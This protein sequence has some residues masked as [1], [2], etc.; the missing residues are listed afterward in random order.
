[1][2]QI[3]GTFSQSNL[4]LSFMSYACTKTHASEVVSPLEIST[5]AP[6][7]NVPD[8]VDVLPPSLANQLSTSSDEKAVE[9]P[10]AGALD[11]VQ[12]LDPISFPNQPRKGSYSIPAT[13][14][15]VRH[16]L[17]SYGVVARYNVIKKKVHTT[18]PGIQ[19]TTDNADSVALT[20][21]CSL[22]ALN[23]LSPGYVPSYVE[24]IADSAAFNPV[25]DWIN[26]KPWDGEDRL[27]SLCNT[28]TIRE[29]F[30]PFLR[31]ILVRRWL[32][33][34]VAAALMTQG[35]RARG[36][37]TFQG[38]QGI[39]KTAWVMSLV[40]DPLLRDM[41]VKVDHH[42]DANNKDSI[43]TA[44]SHWIVEIGEL[45]SSFKKDIARLKGF[46]TSDQDK[47]RRPYGRT[48]AE[49]ARR[50]VFCATVNESNFLVDMT[51]NTRWWTIPV[52]A[53]NF[54]HTI[55]MQQV[56]AQLAV[57]FRE[58][59]AQWWLNKPEE[60]LLEVHN[61]DHQNVSVIREGM[62][63]H[64]DFE[65]AKHPG[66][67]AMTPTEI[68]KLIGFDKPSNPQCKECGGILRQMLGEPKKIK[69]I[70]KWRVP[71]K[72]TS[73]YLL[74]KISVNDSDDDY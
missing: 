36:V 44:V 11:D 10:L 66:M 49:Y 43:L 35:F 30:P 62:L 40:S 50:T 52:T 33:S 28:L 70:N 12:S 55:D 7:V 18:L 14:Q 5:S 24:V 20:H 37:L 68:L 56:F 58:G 72:R 61:R 45:D 13:I 39:G 22:A 3:L 34:A 23:G 31:D 51:G 73:T 4:G 60:D 42:L 64:I 48:D 71:L 27:P 8:V 29:D 74:N 53:I 63:D 16:I 67:P 2:L 32:L 25:A 15:N 17:T 65:M 47:L 9:K 54:K 69:G 41:L 19:G 1:L 6:S 26:S 57:E 46:L 21:I 38:P 59:N